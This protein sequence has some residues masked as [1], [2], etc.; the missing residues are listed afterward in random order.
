MALTIETVLKD[1]E[2]ALRWLPGSARRMVVVFTGLKA[3]FGGQKLDEFAMSASQ[4]GENN[5][6]FVTDR[7]GGWYAGPDLWTRIV[8]LIGYLQRDERIEEI[9][10]LGN[11]MGGYGALLLPRD[12]RVTRAIAFSPQVSMDPALSGDRRW[13]DVEATVGPLPERDLPG[14]VAAS[15]T[16]YY[17]VAARGC[18]EDVAHLALMPG[19]RRVHRWILP[20]GRHNIAGGLKMAGLL[21]DVI[22]A[23]VRGRK[24]RADALLS[25]YAGELA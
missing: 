19:H 8:G 16:Q 4:G 24:A 17:L 21:P 7:R 14:T 2:L 9:V 3:R 25:R 18:A 13:P 23:L 12:L 22:D 11:S 15:R 10:T 5:V 6:L 1:E 20:G